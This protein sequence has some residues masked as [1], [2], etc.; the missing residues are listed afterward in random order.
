MRICALLCLAMLLAPT[1]AQAVTCKEFSSCEEAVHAWCTGAHPRADGDN[2]GIPCENVCP[3]RAIVMAIQ[4][5][6]GC[7]R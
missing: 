6:I 7:S 1:S 4:A 3:T 2:D 5:S